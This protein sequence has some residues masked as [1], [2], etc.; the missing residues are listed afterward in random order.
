MKK[1]CVD[2]KKEK[3]IEEFGLSRASGKNNFHASDIP[4]YKNKC[5]P[6]LA[7]Y[8]R[9][10]RKKNPGYISSGKVKAYPK[11]ER[12]LLSA[13]SNRITGARQ[14]NKRNNYPFNID[15]EYMYSLY[16]QQKGQC[17]IS[18][19]TLQIGKNSPLGLS[20]DK[21]SPKKGYTKGNVQWLLWA[22]NRAKGDL[23]TEEF[24]DLCRLI[25]RR[26]NDYPEREYTQV[27]GSA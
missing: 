3:P 16:Q 4:Q 26:C 25:S 21:I 5:K 13:I 7:E 8:A 17:A 2:C 23:D 1:V 15:K 18:G 27:S 9:Q 14:N 6:C 10:W 19:I 20:I 22:V 12:L 24:L 11:E